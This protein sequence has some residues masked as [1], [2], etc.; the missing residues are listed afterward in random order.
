MSESEI[1]QEF[2][3]IVTDWLNSL[4]GTIFDDGS[5]CNSITILSHEIKEEDEDSQI[6]LIE[7]EMFCYAQGEMTKDWIG[8]EF[9]V[10]RDIVGIPKITAWDVIEIQSR[11]I[12]PQT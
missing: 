9:V 12:Y 1:A 10:E 4:A 5:V 7:A 2:L 6:L 3:A 11:P 8:Y